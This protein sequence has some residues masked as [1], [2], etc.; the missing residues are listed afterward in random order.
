M[1]GS[2]RERL[3]YDSYFTI[4]PLAGDTLARVMNL[5][6]VRVWEPAAGK[7]HLASQLRKHGAIVTATELH[8]YPG[9]SPTVR[10]GV[11][12]LA[13]KR[14]PRGCK[15]IITNPPFDQVEAFVRQGLKLM[16]HH[17]YVAMLLRHEWIC[18]KGQ[19]FADL[20]IHYV[21]IRGRLRWFHDGRESPRHNF[22]WVI[23]SNLAVPDRGY[24]Y[25][26]L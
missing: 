4:D 14:A 22:A 6:G 15:A 10:T 2:G 20:F 21:P 17:G 24:G 19:V 3:P 25:M 5:N 23:W 1:I 8:R 18:R 26:H 16:P 13:R 11:D 12:F 9:R 7:G